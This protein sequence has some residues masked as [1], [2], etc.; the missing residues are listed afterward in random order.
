MLLDDSTRGFRKPRTLA[1]AMRLL[2]RMGGRLRNN[3]PPGWLTLARGHEH[4]L[5]LVAGWQMATSG[6]C[7]ER[8]D[9]CRPAPCSAATPP[10]RAAAPPKCRFAPREEHVVA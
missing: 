3:G 1:D 8:S 7:R 5:T 10:A 9:R 2:A 4:L 6:F